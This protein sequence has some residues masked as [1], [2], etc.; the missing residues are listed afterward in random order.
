MNKCHLLFLLLSLQLSLGIKAQ[1]V[2]DSL[3]QLI[4][5][6]KGD[7]ARARLYKTIVDQLGDQ[8]QKALIYAK[9]GLSLTQKMRWSKGIGVFSNFLGGIHNDLGNYDQAEQ[10]I[11]A[12]LK[13]HQAN[14]DSFNLAS[15]YNSLGN[16]YSRR[17]QNLPGV[18]ACL[19]ALQ[20]AEQSGSSALLPVILGNISIMYSNQS[21]LDKAFSYQRRALAQ[22][23]QLGDSIGMA[24]AY[25]SLANFYQLKS[26][27]T[28]ALKYYQKCIDLY[29]KKKL[30]LKLAETYQN[31]ALLYAS[32]PARLKRQLQA[33]DIWDQS[34]P[35]H[36]L[37]ITNRGNIAWTYLDLAERDPAQKSYALAQATQFCQRAMTLADSVKDQGNQHFLLSLKAVLEAA[38]GNHA[39]AYQ[40]LYRYH[41]QYDSI[42]SQESKN[43]LAEAEGNYL[44]EKKNAEI[45]IQSLTISN[46]RKVQ[47]AF[48]LGSLLLLLIAFLFYRLSQIRRKSNQ[49]LQELNQSLDQANRQKAQL[50]AVLS[51]DL[52]HP[53][54]N[55]ISLLHL[56]KN[57]PDLL[58]P[59]LAA[60]NQARITNNTEVLLENLENMLLWSKEQ[61]QQAAVE[62]QKVQVQ[63]LFQRLHNTFSAQHSIHWT[64]ECPDDLHIHTDPNYLWIILQNLSSNASKALSKQHNAGIQWKAWQEDKQGWISISDNGPGFPATVLEGFQKEHSETLL[65][66]FGLQV[67]HDFA[68]KLGIELLFENPSEG[69]ARVSLKMPL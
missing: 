40:A 42:Y 65:S 28:Q 63:E 1:S 60:Q 45:A 34:L 20:I 32:I 67:V 7:T 54:S 48:A 49:Q 51:H 68:Q 62:P 50:L 56:Q 17:G 22:Y 23:Q 47:W 12:A 18:D 11:K 8:P 10:Y 41:E 31:Q 64:F 46:Q 58:T 13:I 27:T 36:Q 16:V 2:A 26:D 43:K 35:A 5:Q 14:R 37:S 19:K 69:G 66:G 44:L 4:P 29:S 61:M 55:L 25:K 15:T 38:K 39:D 30:T 53:L 52:R 9:K 59:E 24:T 3:I 21:N 6:T 57:A 33:Q